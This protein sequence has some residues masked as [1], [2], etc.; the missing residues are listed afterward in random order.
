MADIIGILNV[1]LI[2]Y[3]SLAQSVERTN[4]VTTEENG[5]VTPHGRAKE[6][7]IS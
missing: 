4:L 6:F 5:V 3:S 7:E 1:S 2:S